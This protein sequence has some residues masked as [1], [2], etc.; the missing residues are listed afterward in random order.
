MS[1]LDGWFQVYSSEPSGW[2]HIVLNFIGPDNGQ[3][4]RIYYDGEQTGSDNTKNV[5]AFQ[6][7]DS[8]VVVGRQFIDEDD[9]YASVDVDELILFNQALTDQNILDMNN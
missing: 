7:G 3:G 6:S 9:H 2:T 5:H 4:I 1:L 8:R